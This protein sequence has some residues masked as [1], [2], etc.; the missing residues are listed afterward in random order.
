MSAH[1][2]AY[3]E[4]LVGRCTRS[5]R[6]QVHVH[7]ERPGRKKIDVAD[8]RFL[9]KLAQGRVKQARIRRLDVSTGLKPATQ[10]GVQH[11]EHAL[12]VG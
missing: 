6:Y 4:V 1:D 9:A 8:A 3:V 2:E 7:V 12:R 5:R 11:Q 10:L